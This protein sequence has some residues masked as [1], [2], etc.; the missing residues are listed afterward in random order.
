MRKALGD[1]AEEPKYIEPVARRGY[2]LMV[3]VEWIARSDSR[4]GAGRP[5]EPGHAMAL[6]CSM[7]RR[8]GALTGQDGLALPRAGYHRRRRHGRGVSGRRPQAG[9]AG[10]AEVPAGR[11]GRDPRRWS[12]SA[13]GACRLGAGPSQH[14]LHLRIRRAR[15]QPFIVMQLLEGETLRDRRR[16]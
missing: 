2:R 12:D 9:P 6:R 16:C 1:S 8:S 3:P 11:T 10:G 4:C 15:G 5:S 7:Q 13:R 14:L